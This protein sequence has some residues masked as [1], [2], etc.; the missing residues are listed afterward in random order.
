[1]RDRPVGR[2]DSN[3]RLS[4]DGTAFSDIVGESPALTRALDQIRNIGPTDSTVLLMGETGTGKELFANAVHACSPRRNR[5]LVRVNCAALSPTL[6]E[7]E[8]FGHERGS[9]TD[10]ITTRVGRFELADKGTIFLDEIGDLPLELQAK[11]LR[12]LQEREFERLGS[13]HSRRVDVRVVAATHRDLPA[14]IARG[15]FRADL[16]YRLSVYPIRVP[17]LRDRLDDLPLLVSHFISQ[18]QQR[19]RRHITT[20]PDQVVEALRQHSWPGNIR[21]LE[22]VIVTALIVSTGST[23]V[24]DHSFY[25]A[26]AASAGA[27]SIAAPPDQDTLESL[28]RRHIETVLHRTGWRING[29]GNAAEQLKL[30]PNTL[31]FR[32]RKLGIA[33]PA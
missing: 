21:E 2:P 14:A 16:F 7:S 23:L 15:E 6:I 18:H 32:M 10:A 31:R 3:G 19:M 1:M 26:C 17:S 9:F 13:S 20:V 22:N 33:R 25:Q 29:K 5:Q 8:L 4:S 11:M 28:Q 27:R 24:L 12:V 30:H